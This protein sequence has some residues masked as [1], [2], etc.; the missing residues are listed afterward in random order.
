MWISLRYAISG[1]SSVLL[2]RFR[3]VFNWVVWFWFY[4]T[5]LKC[6]PIEL[7]S[8]TNGKT[9]KQQSGS[10]VFSGQTQPRVVNIIVLV[11]CL[12]GISFSPGAIIGD[13][14][15]KRAPFLVLGLSLW[16]G[17]IFLFLEQ[18]APSRVAHARTCCV[19]F[20][21]CSAEEIA[22][23]INYRTFWYFS[24]TTQYVFY[25]NCLISRALIGSFLSSIRVQTD[26]ILI[27]ASFQVQ[28]SAVKLP[29]F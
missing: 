6:A 18:I 24:S 9:G 2:S 3:A 20:C 27:C 10:S 26:T 16:Y 11:L 19:D 17:T 5:Q 29:T 22:P 7:Y 23:K 13:R 28:L 15:R 12:S 4:D 8:Y 21:G 25:N 1:G 14:D